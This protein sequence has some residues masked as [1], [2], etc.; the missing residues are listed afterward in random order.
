MWSFS[1]VIDETVHN[2]FADMFDRSL[3]SSRLGLTRGF[4]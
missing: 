4:K 3:T 2:D 1:A